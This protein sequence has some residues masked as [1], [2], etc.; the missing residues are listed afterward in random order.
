[1][2]QHHLHQ[3]SLEEL[4]GQFLQTLLVQVMLQHFQLELPP[5]TVRHQMA[6]GMLLAVALLMSN[7]LLL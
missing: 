4:H 5:L 7:L 3:K 6:L 2:L 1:M